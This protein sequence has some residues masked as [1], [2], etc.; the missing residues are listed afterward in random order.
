VSAIIFLAIAALVI[1]L[2]GDHT[3]FARSFLRHLL[4]AL[5]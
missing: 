2:G 4:R 1:L 5:H 3:N